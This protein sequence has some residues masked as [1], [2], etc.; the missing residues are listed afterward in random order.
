MK[1][2]EDSIKYLKNAITT[3][4][5]VG[6]ETMV[7][8]P[9]LV[10]AMDENRAVFILQNKDVPD[11]EYGSIGLTRLPSLAS[12]MRIAEELKDYSISATT[13]NEDEDMF[14]R[15]LVITATGLKVDY[16]CADPVKLVAASQAG[17][18]Q[19]NDDMEFCVE[20]EDCAVDM[21]QK[22]QAA[23]KSETVSIISNDGVT[24][25]LLDVNNDV[26]AHQFADDAVN[27][28]G[29]DTTKFAHRYPTK[30]LL[31]LFKNADEGLLTISKRGLLCISINGLSVYIFPQV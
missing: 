8:T 25:E 21:L 11:M 13:L 1:L 29:N 20:F 14:A 18:K 12:R 22:G 31:M 26:F 5:L 24:F 7:I 17:P 4:Q 23:M 6:A 3:A 16:R 2:K 27:L 10:R 9:G 30:N 28:L 15:A 19:M